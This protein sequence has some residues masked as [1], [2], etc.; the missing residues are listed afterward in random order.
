MLGAIPAGLKL[1]PA[2]AQTSEI[3]V[4]NWGGDAVPAYDAIWAQPFNAANPGAKALIT[5]KS[6][7]TLE[8]MR[9]TFMPVSPSR[10]LFGGIVSTARSRPASTARRAA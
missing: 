9:P 6:T 4:V 1:T 3:V 7:V 8:I 2:H 10:V 5:V